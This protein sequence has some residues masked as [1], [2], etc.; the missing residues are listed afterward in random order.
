MPSRSKT[1]AAET[2]V[3]LP[4]SL[5][6]TFLSEIDALEVGN[7]ADVLRSAFADDGQDAEIIS[8][9]ENR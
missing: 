8:V 2:S 9:V 6:L 3:A 4:K 7:V 1:S 5:K